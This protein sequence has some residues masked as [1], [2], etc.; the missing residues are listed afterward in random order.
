[1]QYVN[2]L[3]TVKNK[4]TVLTGGGGILAG[5]MYKGLLQ[6]GAKVILLDINEENLRIK[7]K[8]CWGRNDIVKV[9]FFHF[10]LISFILNYK[11]KPARGR[12]VE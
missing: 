2:T 3:F 5:E 6:A 8:M 12:F 1:M 10:C 9:D 7:V 11:N 4:V